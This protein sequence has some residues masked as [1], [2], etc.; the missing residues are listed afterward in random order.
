MR[1]GALAVFAAIHAWALEGYVY[2]TQMDARAA[3]ARL[4]TYVPDITA[5]AGERWEIT[6]QHAVTVRHVVEARRHKAIKS[7]RLFGVRRPLRELPN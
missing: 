5:L 7:E 2:R 4:E 3:L 6:D 1:H